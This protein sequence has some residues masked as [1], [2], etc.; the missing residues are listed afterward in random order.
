MKDKTTKIILLIGF[1]IL[2][3]MFFVRENNISKKKIFLNYI[4]LEREY[5][6]YTG[7]LVGR[8][9]NGVIHKEERYVLGK[10]MGM[11]KVYD[12]EGNM[13]VSNFIF[14]YNPFF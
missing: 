1:L 10:G 2:I 9:E 3:I 7:K 6:P 12:E 8:Y 14:G 4:Y 5:F 13:I 11:Q